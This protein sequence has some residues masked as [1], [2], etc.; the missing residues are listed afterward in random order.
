MHLLVRLMRPLASLPAVAVARGKSAACPVLTSLKG[1][2]CNF[3]LQGDN[4]RFASELWALGAARP[5]QQMWPHTRGKWLD[6][7]PRRL[8]AWLSHVS[9]GVIRAPGCGGCSQQ[10]HSAS[11]SSR[12]LFFPF[13]EPPYG[14]QRVKAVSQFRRNDFLY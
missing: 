6:R 5:S 4:R 12:R 3:S 8:W 13:P 14:W 11:L 2:S 1:P 7:I 9:G 10:P